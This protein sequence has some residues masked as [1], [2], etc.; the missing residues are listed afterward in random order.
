MSLP[1]IRYISDDGRRLMNTDEM[2]RDNSDSYIL[3]ILRSLPNNWPAS[4]CGT[5]NLHCKF[6]DER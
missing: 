2:V 6:N 3:T 4:P 1:R 5:S